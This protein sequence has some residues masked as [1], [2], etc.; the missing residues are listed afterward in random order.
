MADTNDARDAPRARP[1]EGER[2]RMTH[3]DATDE[4]ELDWL[5]THSR[6]ALT[7]RPVQ[8]TKEKKTKGGSSRQVAWEHERD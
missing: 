7:Q 5:L 6:Q 4:R 8:R 1:R 2:Q 3:A